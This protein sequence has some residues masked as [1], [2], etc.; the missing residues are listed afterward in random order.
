M[1]VGTRTRFTLPTKSELSRNTQSK[2]YICSNSHSKKK[3]HISTT[4]FLCYCVVC[5]LL[6]IW[7]KKKLTLRFE[8]IEDG[9]TLG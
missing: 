6:L 7:H 4:L 8:C 2:L 1:N 3:P 9:K 5:C